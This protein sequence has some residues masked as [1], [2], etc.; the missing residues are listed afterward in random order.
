MYLDLS[1]TKTPIPKPTNPMSCSK[2]K[3]R[4]ISK[5][6]YDPSSHLTLL[7][8]T[9]SLCNSLKKT[10]KTNKKKG[11]GREKKK[12]WGGGGIRLV[13]GFVHTLQR[14]RRESLC[15][16]KSRRMDECNILVWYISG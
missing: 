1:P 6:Y 15:V 3:Y 2:K 16:D 8:F 13:S 5:D 12:T 11:K 4:K 7:T 10:N 14:Q 9:Y